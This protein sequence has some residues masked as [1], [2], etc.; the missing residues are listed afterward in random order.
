[1]SV[2]R[3]CFTKQHQICK[4]KANTKTD[5]FL[6]SD[7]SCLHT[8]GLRPHHWRISNFFSFGFD[9]ALQAEYTVLA[10]KLGDY[11]VRLLD[12]VHGNAELNAILNAGDDSSDDPCRPHGE[13]ARLQLAIDCKEKKVFKPANNNNNNK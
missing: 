9:F 4:T 6:V 2:T 11:V 12:K 8:D 5:F 1:M 3:P 13:L 7:R 10:N